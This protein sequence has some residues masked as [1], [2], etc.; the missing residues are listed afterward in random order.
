[1]RLRLKCATCGNEVVLDDL[2]CQRLIERLQIRS[3]A[4]Y[5]ADELGN[6]PEDDDA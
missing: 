6:D 1:M 5:D 3:E 4:D 2:Q